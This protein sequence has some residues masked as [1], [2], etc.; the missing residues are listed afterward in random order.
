MKPGAY[1]KFYVEA[2]SKKSFGPISLLGP[3]HKILEYACGLQRVPALSLNQNPIFEI[4]S[5]YFQIV[6]FHLRPG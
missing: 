5:K 4:A 2:S 6:S 3:H 1:C